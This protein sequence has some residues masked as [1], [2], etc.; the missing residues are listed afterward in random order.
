MRGEFSEEEKGRV[1]LIAAG[2]VI[3]KGAAFGRAMNR[4]SRLPA[5]A[6]QRRLIGENLEIDQWI[7]DSFKVHLHVRFQRP[8]SHFSLPVLETHLS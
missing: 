3:S 6:A 5:V 7:G 8:I 2:K 1:V 4:R